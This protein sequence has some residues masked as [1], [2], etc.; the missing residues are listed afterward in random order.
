M[1]FETASNV[2]KKQWRFKETSC[3]TQC[4]FP[5]NKNYINDEFIKIGVPLEDCL[6]QQTDKELVNK[7]TNEMLNGSNFSPSWVIYGKRLKNGE[8]IPFWHKKLYVLDGNHRLMSNKECG[9]T[10]VEVIIPLSNYKLYGLN[11]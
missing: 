3:E 4:V 2:F 6:L 5:Y 8:V 9:N 11:K 7:Y 10:N 1:N